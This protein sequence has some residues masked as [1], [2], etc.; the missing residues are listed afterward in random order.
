MAAHVSKDRQCSGGND[1][2]ADGQSIQA[3][4]QVHGITRSNDHQHDK[5]HERRKGQRPQ[6]RIMAQAFDHQVRP[7]LLH[8]WNHQVS[9]ILADGSKRY[10]DEA[11]EGGR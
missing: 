7:E 11:D 2:A 1:C 4:G 5:Q 8:E 9:G 10:Q 3:I 6:M